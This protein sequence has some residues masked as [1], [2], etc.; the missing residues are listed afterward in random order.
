MKTNIKNGL[1]LGF[2]ALVA[3]GL[4]KFYQVAEVPD[5]QWILLPTKTL[6]QG[7]TSLQFSYDP[8]QG[9]INTA[10]QFVIAKSC[11]GVNFLIIVFCTSVFGFTLRLSQFRQ[12]L[13]SLP[14][15]LG[16][17]YV[18]TIAVN[19]FRIINSLVFN[20]AQIP[21]MNASQLHK[22][23]GVIVYLSFLLIYYL[24]IHYFFQKKFTSKTTQYSPIL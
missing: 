4:K 17:A 21:G 23:E 20:A 13:L 10:H 16:I 8:A 22:T 19:A 15:F 2:M 3:F 18:L 7:F 6:V 24:T 9:H 1:I 14:S 12:Q 11:A 5:L